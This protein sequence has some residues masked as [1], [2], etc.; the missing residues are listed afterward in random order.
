MMSVICNKLYR[1]F[2]HGNVLNGNNS[3]QIVLRLHAIRS[4]IEFLRWYRHRKYRIDHLYANFQT[5]NMQT[6][7]WLIRP[8][9]IAHK[10]HNYI[11]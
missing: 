1:K 3:L 9:Y 6:T 8:I 4:I 10:E 7:V 2:Y 5:P 11:N